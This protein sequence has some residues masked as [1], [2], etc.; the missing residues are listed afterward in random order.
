MV[1]VNQTN[2]SNTKSEWIKES[3]QNAEIFFRLGRKLK[4]Q[5][6]ICYLQGTHLR[7][8]YLNRWKTITRKPG[9]PLS[10]K[11]KRLHG[12]LFWFYFLVV[13]YIESNTLHVCIWQVLYHW[14]IYISSPNIDFKTKMNVTR[15]ETPVFYNGKKISSAQSYNH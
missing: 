15:G 11:K 3:N 14:A 10:E 4:I 2:T 5:S 12:F 6:I 7:F 13:L 9:I 8:K 1:E